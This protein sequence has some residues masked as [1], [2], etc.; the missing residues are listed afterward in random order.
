MILSNH[1][2]ELPQLVADLGLAPLIDRTITSAMVGAEKPNRRIFE[3][4]MDVA[5]AG[6]DVWMVGDNPVADIGGAE[7][8]GIRAIHITP[9]CTLTDAANQIVDNSARAQTGAASAAR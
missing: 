8:V 2:P 7:A 6:D 5:D 9:N 3:Y 1:A 4:A